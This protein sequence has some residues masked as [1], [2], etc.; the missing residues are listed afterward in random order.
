M[1][2][3]AGTDIEDMT[4]GQR[5]GVLIEELEMSQSVLGRMCGR[6]PSYVHNIVRRGQGTTQDFAQELL[7]EVGVNLNWLF[8]GVGPM[9]RAGVSRKVSA[10][11]EQ[12]PADFDA[13]GVVA[14]MHHASEHL[15]EAAEVLENS[16]R[17]GKGRQR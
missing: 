16:R 3:E 6:S 12:I 5:L 2:D 11:A 15:L 13:S 9:L 8:G 14:Q 7:A 10:S 17:S 4:P 1:S